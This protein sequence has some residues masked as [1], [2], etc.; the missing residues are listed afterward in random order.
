MAAMLCWVAQPKFG[1]GT[2]PETLRK[3]AQ[4]R[5]TPN[6][7]M[8][9]G[10]TETWL[11]ALAD[12]RTLEAYPGT[13]G[14]VL[15][16]I[17]AQAVDEA[18]RPLPAGESGVLRFRGKGVASG[19][20]GVPEDPTGMHKA[21]RNGWC[22][23]GDVGRVTAEGLL[24]VEGRVDD[25]INVGGPKINSSVVEGVLLSH[26][27]VKEVAAFGVR[28]PEGRDWLVAA[29]VPACRH[30]VHRLPRQPA[31]APAARSRA[32]SG[33]SCCDGRSTA[34][35]CRF[36][37]PG[38]RPVPDGTEYPEAA[39]GL[40]RRSRPE[41]RVPSASRRRRWSEDGATEP[42]WHR[43]AP[44]QQ[45]AYQARAASVGQA[46]RSESRIGTEEKTNWIA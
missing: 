3:R 6:L 43:K 5:I 14:K 1:G 29:V 12:P 4:A 46:T 7:Y 38:A 15:P 34:R 19:Y 40:I 27:D 41:R 39:Q 45:G 37:R 24:Y 2:L 16:W 28:S 13:A 9:Y 25:V 10:A 30:R 36:H 23:V 35:G 20:H 42:R 33:R 32:S 31:P 22:Y 11:L 44:L 17:E 21:F 8:V 18:D 26:P